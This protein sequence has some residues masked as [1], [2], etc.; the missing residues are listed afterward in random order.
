MSCSLSRL[1]QNVV[2]HLTSDRHAG[3]DPASSLMKAVELIWVPDV[4]WR[5][6]KAKTDRVRNGK[7]AP[8]TVPTTATRYGSRE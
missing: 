6:W 1:C 4:S 5:S 2:K 3:L 8:Y 7:R